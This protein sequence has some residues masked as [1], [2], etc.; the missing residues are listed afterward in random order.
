MKYAIS[1]IV[2]DSDIRGVKTIEISDR[3]I[4]MFVIHRSSVRAVQQM[5]DLQM[6]GVY[7]LFGEGDVQ[8]QCYIGHS[9]NVA[10]RIKDHLASEDKIF[11]EYICAFTA[12]TGIDKV[13]SLYLESLSIAEA[14]NAKSYEIKNKITQ[15]TVPQMSD[16]KIVGCNNNFEIIKTLL[17]IFGYDVFNSVS[18]LKHD[19]ESKDSERLQFVRNKELRAEAILLENKNIIV[20]KGAKFSKTLSNTIS[21]SDK[22]LQKEYIEKGLLIEVGDFL[23]LNEDTIFNSS[24]KAASLIIGSPSSG[25]KV[26]GLKK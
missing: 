4:K 16:S 7:F 6:P 11:F 15:T 2:D 24:S 20:L 9:E 8:D 26:F 23:L 5:S 17:S 22:R 19:I 25:P 12:G 21:D 10:A 13:D 14:Y 18:D 3:K 1:M